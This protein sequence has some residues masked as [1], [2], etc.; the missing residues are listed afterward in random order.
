MA[1]MTGKAKGQTEKA[2]IER[3][4]F[5]VSV[6]IDDP[7]TR[8]DFL[9]RAC[10]GDDSMLSRISE[11]IETQDA[12]EE[13]FRTATIAR[14]EAGLDV[15]EALCE[16]APANPAAGSDAANES[17]LWI[18]RYLLLERIGEGGC[19]VVYLA[20]QSEPVRRKVALKIIRR[21]LDTERVIARFESERQ[22]LAMMD[23]PGIAKVLDA[24]TTADGRPFFAM[25]LVDGVRITTYCDTRHLSLRQRLGLFAQVCQAIQHAHQKGIIHRDIKPSNILV[26]TLDGHIAPKVI[27]F[28]IARAVEGRIP[29]ET[30]FT[31]GGELLGTPAYMSPEQAEGRETLDTRGDIYSLGILLYELLTAHTPF[32]SKRLASVGTYE[33]MRILREEEPLPPSAMIGSLAVDDL[34]LVASNRGIHPRHL[35]S[36]VRGDLDGIVLKAIAKDCHERYAT[37]AGLAADVE[38]HLNDEP[39]SARPPGQFYLFAK[40]VRRNKLAFSAA[41]AIA[42]AL[43]VGATASTWFYLREREARQLAEAARANEASLLRQSRAREEIAMASILL[44]EGK[45]NEAD[46]IMAHRPLSSIEPSGEALFVFRSYGDWNAIR[47]RWQQ[48]AECYDHFIRAGGFGRVYFGEIPW[49]LMAVGVSQVEADR[50]EAYQELRM[51]CMANYTNWT[52]YA[53]GAIVL[54]S[55][56]L[57]PADS[58]VLAGLQPLADL[59]E[60]TLNTHTL[61]L[62]NANQ[63]A[64]AAMSM[65]LVEYRKG[66]DQ[67]ALNWCRRGL[68]FPHRND[69]RSATIHAIGAMAAQRLGQVELGSK[70]LASA[71]EFDKMTYLPDLSQPKGLGQV[72]WHDIAITRVLLKEAERELE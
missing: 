22:A 31:L 55:C 30:R 1:L 8:I 56:L 59:V 67:A 42:F 47:G 10:A 65:A 34:A 66:N 50:W 46:E 24:G 20:E 62:V 60:N 37:V 53:L 18:D 58:D 51:H 49:I 6:G 72:Y 27:D 4:L 33:T 57:S 68:D 3:A 36:L 45:V 9:V 43:V 35:I 28:G 61:G 11:W 40:L 13:F 12:A 44:A 70:E 69:A 23:H 21:G 64:F 14:S 54:K 52:D 17:G 29:G 19:G 41:L 2:Q 15:F 63:G 38:R 7:P 5:D 71:R 16:D 39:V 48:A 26:T 25:E 32:D